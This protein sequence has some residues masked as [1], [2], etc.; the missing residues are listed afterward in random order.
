MAV[1]HAVTPKKGRAIL[2]DGRHYHCGTS[3]AKHDVESCSI[4]I[5]FDS[6]R[7]VA[8]DFRDAIASITIRTPGIAAGLVQPG[9]SFANLFRVLLF[10]LVQKLPAK[11][12]VK[13]LGRRL[14]V[15]PHGGAGQDCGRPRQWRRR[16]RKATRRQ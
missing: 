5:S 9:H 13:L 15:L 1:L 14:G 16:P 12:R 8:E 7:R 4:M 6:P 3:P 11:P 10:R 2:F